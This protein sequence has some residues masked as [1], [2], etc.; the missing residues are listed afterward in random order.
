MLLKDADGNII[1]DE[2]KKEIIGV[3]EEFW[4]IILE[5]E[6]VFQ[7]LKELVETLQAEVE[8]L[9]QQ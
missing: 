7:D 4:E 8:E 1:L 9:K 6:K 5:Y 3:N 2:A